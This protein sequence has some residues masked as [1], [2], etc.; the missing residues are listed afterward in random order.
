MW[1]MGQWVLKSQ[2]CPKITL[3]D[4]LSFG[5][6]SPGHVYSCINTQGHEAP[7]QKHWMVRIACVYFF[8]LMVL[9]LSVFTDVLFEFEQARFSSIAILQM[10]VYN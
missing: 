2:F 4:N 1:V 3:R 6:R 8:T 10:L 5:T 7:S 9:I